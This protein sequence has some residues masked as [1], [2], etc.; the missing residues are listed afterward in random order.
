MDMG[1]ELQMRYNNKHFLEC[2]SAK[3]KKELHANMFELKR[4]MHLSERKQ[5]TVPF[6]G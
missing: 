4:Q 1:V 6:Q 3:K 2:I 5:K